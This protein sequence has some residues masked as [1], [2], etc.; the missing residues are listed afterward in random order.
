MSSDERR[1]SAASAEGKRDEGKFKTESE[2]PYR[3]SIQ[4]REGREGDIGVLCG[5]SR[6]RGWLS[7]LITDDRVSARRDDECA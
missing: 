4:R 1:D 6:G 7:V 2:N 3:S 5:R